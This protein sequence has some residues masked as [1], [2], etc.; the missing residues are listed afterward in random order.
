M[1]CGLLDVDDRNRSFPGQAPAPTGQP[2]IEH[3]VTDH[4]RAWRR[5]GRVM[6]GLHPK[7]FPRQRPGK[8]AA[9]KW[10]SRGICRAGRTNRKLRA[11]KLK[12]T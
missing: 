9:A 4:H 6:S 12:E 11:I 10:Q 3:A 7:W 5:V 1:S 2:H 8:P